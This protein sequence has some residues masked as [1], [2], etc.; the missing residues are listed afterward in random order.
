LSVRELLFMS[1]PETL[2]KVEYDIQNGNLGLARDRLHG[3]MLSY[4]D[5]LS[6]RVKL[7]EVYWKFQQP[8][9][10]GRYWYLVEERSPEMEAAVQAF[11][12]M[13]GHNPLRI[14]RALKFQGELSGI[15]GS[16]AGRVISDLMEIVKDRHNEEILLGLPGMPPKI[17][18][19]NMR[20]GGQG[21]DFG[22]W[23]VFIIVMCLI[24]IGL[25]TVV[26]WIF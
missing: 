18:E 17:K 15:E 4:P 22:C 12:K 2:R 11:E 25:I 14:M 23:I 5:D 21:S 1:K 9:M 26:G 7:A 19:S 3:L 13:Q 6:L 20:H 16:Y 24:L 8:V 10:A